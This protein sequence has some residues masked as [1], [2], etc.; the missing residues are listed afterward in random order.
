RLAPR[1]P[2]RLDLL[3]ELEQR[4]RLNSPPRGAAPADDRQP[5]S[6]N[7]FVERSHAHAELG[8]GLPLR[9]A[10]FEQRPQLPFQLPQPRPRFRLPCLS[11]EQPQLD[12]RREQTSG[13]LLVHP[14]TLASGLRLEPLFTNPD[15]GGAA[16][17]A[18]GAN[19]SPTWKRTAPA[20]RSA[21]ASASS[22]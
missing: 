19:G 1:P 17:R 3:G 18:H 9:H 10:R 15:C 22:R 13:R 21:R 4:T 8:A 2:Q 11:H 6:G 7:P 16:Y 20:T 14:N 12:D 5:P